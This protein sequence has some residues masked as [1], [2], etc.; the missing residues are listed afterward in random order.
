VRTPCE[1]QGLWCSL[2]SAEPFPEVEPAQGPHSPRPGGYAQWSELEGWMN[3][4]GVR[5]A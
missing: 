2:P 3:S 4:H 5:E 1:V